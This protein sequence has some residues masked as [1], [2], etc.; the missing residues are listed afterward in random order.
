MKM[1]R[2]RTVKVLKCCK[3]HSADKVSRQRARKVRMSIENNKILEHH[4]SNEDLQRAW[5]QPEEYKRFKH[6]KA[7]TIR[8]FRS[9]CCDLGA[10]D[11]QNHCVRGLE[12]QATSEIFRYRANAIKR[13]IQGVLQQQEMLRQFGKKDDGALG[14][15]SMVYSAPARKFAFS[16]GALDAQS[17]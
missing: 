6:D 8:A 3:A 10:L 9:A 7:Q 16:L 4:A 17:Y 13:V 12:M 2:K 15:V 14:M 5:Y 11:P 1:C